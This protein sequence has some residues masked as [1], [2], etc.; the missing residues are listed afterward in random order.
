ML[1]R[2]VV[3]NRSDTTNWLD[4]LGGWRPKAELVD[5]QG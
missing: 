3:S 2:L 5:R 4:T 1:G